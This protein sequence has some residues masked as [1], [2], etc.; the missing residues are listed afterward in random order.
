MDVDFAARMEQLG[1]AFSQLGS[2]SIEERHVVAVAWEATA[3][4]REQALRASEPP[5]LESGD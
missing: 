5:Q 3:V 1:A 2:L 4:H